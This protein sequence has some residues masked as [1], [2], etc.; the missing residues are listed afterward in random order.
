MMEGNAHR[1]EYPDFLYIPLHD[2]TAF[3]RGIVWLSSINTIAVSFNVATTYFGD[4]I[5]PHCCNTISC[6]TH[7]LSIPISIYLKRV[8]HIAIISII[9]A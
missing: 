6:H 3:N 5:A 9:V 1:K 8:G 2:D 4:F 7:I